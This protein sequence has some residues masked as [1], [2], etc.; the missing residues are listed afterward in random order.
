MTD[1]TRGWTTRIQGLLVHR[2]DEWQKSLDSWSNEEMNAKNPWTIDPTRRWMAK[3]QGLL[4]QREDEL[5]KI[6]GCWQFLG[7]S[8]LK[9]LRNNNYRNIVHYIVFCILRITIFFNELLFHTINPVLHFLIIARHQFDQIQ[10]L[11]TVIMFN[12]KID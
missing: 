3:I 10:T 6:L 11:F 12:N 8:Y 9:I 4:V 7:L 1:P 2:K 5:M